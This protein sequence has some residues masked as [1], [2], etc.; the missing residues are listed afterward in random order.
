[1]AT[2]DKKM[3]D[4]P[5]EEIW[6]RYKTSGEIEVRNELIERYAPLVKYV[7]GRM[8]MNMPPQVEFD[9]LVSYGIFGL[10][11][12]IEKYEPSRGF[13]FK[14]YAT[15]RIRGAII[16][17]LRALDWIPRSIRQKSRQLQ[18]VYSELEN[19][20]GRAATDEEAAKELGITVKDLDARLNAVS[21]T[22]VI[23]LD[24]V[25]HVG[26]DD[27]E[28]Q[29]GDSIAGSDKD[30]PN[31]NIEKQEVKRI[32]IEAIKEL[33]PREKE[34]IALYYYEELTLKE[35]G[36]VLGVTESRVSQLHSKAM[37]RLKTKLQKNQD[38][39][40]T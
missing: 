9:D 38:A 1:M 34:V 28:I 35:I 18:T 12:A 17:E 31:Y 19:R 20:L 11:D 27:D 4:S 22:T 10:I 39:F 40:V 16:D 37:I 36:L 15:T 24:D 13:K 14:T 26:A 3:V 32:L 29:I 2:V 21:G 33:P 7:A 30:H 6:S 8:A 23:S 5:D 25:W